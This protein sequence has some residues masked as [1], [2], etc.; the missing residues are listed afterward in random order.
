MKLKIALL[1]D[2]L[3]LAKLVNLWS[4]AEGHE[5]QHE[6]RGKAFIH[7]IEN[8]KFD[9]FIIDWNLPDIS[10]LDVL[11]RIRQTLG[12]NIPV[13]FTTGRNDEQDIV[14]ALNQG[15]D[16]YL[17]KPVKRYEMMAR[18]NVMGRRKR[19]DSDDVKKFM[20]GFFQIDEKFHIIMR[21][22]KPVPLTNKEYELALYLFKNIGKLVSRA[23]ILESV[24]G[25]NSQLDT[26][27]VDT[28]ISRIRK[29][30]QLGETSGLKLMSI[31]QH[32]YRLEKLDTH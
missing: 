2:D 9:L 23:N 26:R 27:T 16:D 15:A 18:M 13:L 11:K 8:H 32:G 4:V 17:V 30:L 19:N 31:Y 25:I 14:S 28:H 21:N 10:G 12:W 5:L 1:E 7:L 22:E 20:I 6:P 3:A 29:K 24:W